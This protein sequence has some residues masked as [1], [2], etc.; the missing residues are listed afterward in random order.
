MSKIHYVAALGNAPEKPINAAA[1]TDL[2]SID[3]N[4]IHVIG[5]V[6]PDPVVTIGSFGP[7][8]L[9]TKRVRFDARIIIHHNP[10]NLLLPIAV[11]RTTNPG[12]VG[13]YYADANGVWREEQWIPADWTQQFLVTPTNSRVTCPIGFTKAFIQLCGM[14]G[15]VGGST[16][17]SR[18]GG[19]LEKTV[20]AVPGQYARLIVGT[21]AVPNASRLYTFPG[22]AAPETPFPDTWM[23]GDLI[24]GASGNAVAT[25]GDYNLPG[26]AGV[27]NAGTNTASQS[28]TGMCAAQSINAGHVKGANYGGGALSVDGVA[29]NGADGACFITWRKW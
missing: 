14:G 13:K 21:Y 28:G 6:S 8:T 12:D 27:Y 5:P 19:Y 25:G 9:V 18:N 10:P 15:A 7:G 1:L 24:C 29:V 11:D 3:S 22:G 2:D 23:V 16:H 26:V 20:P 17:V 4:R